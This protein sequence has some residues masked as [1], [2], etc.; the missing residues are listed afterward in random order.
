MRKRR[1]A[2][3]MRL[4]LVMAFA[5]FVAFFIAEWYEYTQS[6]ALHV[7]ND[8]PI[9]VVFPVNTDST[10]AAFTTRQFGALYYVGEV[11]NIPAAESWKKVSAEISELSKLT[12]GNPLPA[13][14]RITLRPEYCRRAIIQEATAEL[15]RIAP[16]CEV[17]F[18]VLRA[19]Y[20]VT[21]IENINRLIYTGLLL[22]ALFMVL[23]LYFALRAERL[24]DPDES[25]ALA[26]M[27]A[28]RLFMALSHIIFAVISGMYGLVVA[29]AIRFAIGFLPSG[30][31]F[32]PMSSFTDAAMLSTAVFGAYVLISIAVA[33]NQGK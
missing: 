15:R 16:N 11:R 4:T 1:R 9:I 20:A 28:G 24:R 3:A 29:I 32:V 6:D 12:E 13:I 31:P 21:R 33:F 26:A 17:N 7:T 5:A 2:A 30:G 23:L 22:S 18:D 25:R 10:D 19:E 27:G 14:A 8:F